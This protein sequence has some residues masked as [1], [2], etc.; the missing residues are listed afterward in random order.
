L[1]FRIAAIVLPRDFTPDT[2]LTHRE[3]QRA[4]GTMH[5]SNSLLPPD[6]GIFNHYCPAGDNKIAV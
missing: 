4:A 2:A 1:E 3:P 6:Y 5:D